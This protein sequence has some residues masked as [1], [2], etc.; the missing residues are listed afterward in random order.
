LL[1]EEGAKVIV[2]DFGGSAGGEGG[3]KTPADEVVDMIKS[4]GGEA[5]ANYGNVADFNEGEKMVQQAIDTFGRLDIVVNNAGILRDRMVFN[6]SE[7]EWDIV[8]A[9]HLK[10]HFNLTKHASVIFR[11]QRSGVFVNTSSESGLGNMGQANYAAAKEGIIGL[12][13]TVA[14][15]MG[16]YGVRCNAIRPR[17]ATRLTLSPELQEAWERS[18]QQPAGAGQAQAVDANVQAMITNLDPKQVAPL[19]VWLCTDEAA[20]INGRNFLVGGNTIGLYSE[21]ELTRS[22]F[23]DQEWSVDLLSD[24]MPKS[25]AAG[26]KNQWP[27]KEPEAKPA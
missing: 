11:Q 1:A 10:G 13:R 26:L 25:L 27:A 4:A 15:D 17:A 5:A 12:T 18:R 20:N 24:L 23:A 21:P 14:R 6:M 22:L 8:I 16:R 19:V 2:N 7:E 9:V 3:D